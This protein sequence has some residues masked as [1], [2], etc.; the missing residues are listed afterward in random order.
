MYNTQGQMNDHLRHA[1]AF[2]LLIVSSPFLMGFILA[3]TAGLGYLLLI[4]GIP[5]LLGTFTVGALFYLVRGIKLA[6]Q[7]RSRRQRALAALAAPMM[8]LVTISL[9]WPALAAGSFSGAWTRLMINRA[10]YE[11]VIAKAR[12]SGSPSRNSLEQDGD[13]EYLVDPG[14]PVRVAFNPEGFLDNWSGI[15]FDPTGVVMRADGFDPRTGKFVAPDEVTKLFGGDL[16]S[17]RRLWGDYYDCSF[18]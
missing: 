12:K 13:V 17:C 3:W 1:G 6:R 4:L 18:I 5:L 2:F 15:I 14:P 8:M 11:A 10:E 16:V 9:A 7:P